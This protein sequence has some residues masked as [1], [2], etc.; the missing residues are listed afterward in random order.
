MPKFVHDDFAKAYLTEILGLIGKVSAGHPIR[1]ESRE[2]D[3]WF[4]PVAD[5]ASN[6]V[7]LGLLGQLTPSEC[8]IEAFRNPASRSDVRS[9]LGKLFSLCTAVERKATREKRR[10]QEADLPCLLILV[11]S[12]SVAFRRRFGYS[13]TNRD[14]AGIYWMPED[15]RN[16]MVVLNQLPKT[17]DTMWLRM[18]SRGRTQKQAIQEFMQ[19]GESH[20]LR[21]AIADLLSD[22]SANL[23]KRRNL[24]DEEEDLIMN[25][26]PAYLKKQQEW[27]EEGKEAGVQEAEQRIAKNMLQSGL[28]IEVIAEATGLSIEAIQQ[29]QTELK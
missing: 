8:L 10:I 11:P 25:L 5:S 28:A 2:A 23:E 22:L 12:A 20:P 19:L 13:R 14:V 26:S 27:K 1:A 18:L 9:C 3:I 17:Q 16:I 6:R 4:Q 15:C 21:G 29:L 24:T 7:L